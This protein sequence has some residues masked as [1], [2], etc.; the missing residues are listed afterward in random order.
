MTI[1]KSLIAASTALAIAAGS[2]A[3]PTTASAAPFPTYAG[4]AVETQSAVETVGGKRR[5][6]RHHRRHG[7]RLHPGAAAAIGLGAFALG[8]AIA[9]GA[10]QAAPRCR[11]VNV[12]R[13]SPRYRAY[14]VRRERV[15]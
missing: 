8:A 5:H 7:R 1:T 4:A 3:V 9:S 2:I 12:R 14:V 6:R 15:C 11:V 13:W 10:A